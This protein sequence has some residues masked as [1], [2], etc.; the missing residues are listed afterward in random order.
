MSLVAAELQVPEPE[1]E[2]S[3]EPDGGHPVDVEDAQDPRDVG[4]GPLPLL[5]PL[6]LPLLAAPLAVAVAVAAVR[7]GVVGV[8]Y[9][10]A[11][12]EVAEGVEAELVGDVV[13]EVLPERG[14]ASDAEL[15][16][17]AAADDVGELGAGEEAPALEV[18]EL[19]GH[20]LEAV[21]DGV[22]HGCRRRRREEGGS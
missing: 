12:A 10:C 5:A 22:R 1:V 19:V 20:P 8:A 7:L 17:A 11:L 21:L 13:E 2:V 3:L 9:D 18:V 4:E 15:E 14:V 16:V 6:P